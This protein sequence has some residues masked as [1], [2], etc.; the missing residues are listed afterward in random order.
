M[1]RALTLVSLTGLAFTSVTARALT[2]EDLRADPG[3]TCAL[4]L[5]RGDLIAAAVVGPL[6]FEQGVAETP[7]RLRA[8]LRAA[9]ERGDKRASAALGWWRRAA[10]AGCSWGG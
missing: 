1:I 4:Y 8:L 7:A 9:A 6:G 3:W 2:P 5:A 10:E